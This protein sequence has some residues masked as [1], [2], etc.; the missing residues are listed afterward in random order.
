M[1][2]NNQEKKFFDEA[3]NKAENKLAKNQ[4]KSVWKPRLVWF[5][6]RHHF[7][8]TAKINTQEIHTTSR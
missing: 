5:H 2:L 1:M 3:D 7:K 8:M 6:A 4:K